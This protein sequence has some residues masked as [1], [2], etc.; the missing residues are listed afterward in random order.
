[1]DKIS[2]LFQGIENEFK[3]S[4]TPTNEDISA[5]RDTNRKSLEDARVQVQNQIDQSFVEIIGYIKFKRASMQSLLSLRDYIDRELQA[6]ASAPPIS[7][8]GISI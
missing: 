6:L 4:V 2:I 1:M 7:R 8:G 3:V 5:T